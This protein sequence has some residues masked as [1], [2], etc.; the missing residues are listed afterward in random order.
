MGSFSIIKKLGFTLF[1]QAE[2]IA[3]GKLFRV[4]PNI[5]H[6]VFITPGLSKKGICIS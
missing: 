4:L 1:S 3:H 2:E 5:P 6:S